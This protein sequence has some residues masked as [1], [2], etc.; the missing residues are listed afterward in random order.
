MSDLAPEKL[1]EMINPQIT[2]I[3]IGKRTLRKIK[4]Y[5]LSLGDEIKVSNIFNEV[6]SVLF[7]SLSMAEDENKM[8]MVAVVT[9][10]F[11]LIRENLGSVLSLITDEDGEQLVN[12]ITNVQAEEVINT[13]IRTNFGEVSKNLKG[14]LEKMKT[15]FLSGRP[16]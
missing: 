12:D 5:P 6:V 16:S 15:L 10:F 9:T 2:E 4:V 1:D 14:L 11:K 13:I 3:T 7:A 8:N